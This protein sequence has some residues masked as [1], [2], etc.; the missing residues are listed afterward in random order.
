M[1]CLYYMVVLEYSPQ[2]KSCF[3]LGTKFSYNPA[4]TLLHDIDKF[5]EVTSLDAYAFRNTTALI[6]AILPAN[7]KKVGASLFVS[8]GLI[9]CTIEEGGMTSLSVSM[10]SSC[11]KQ[12]SVEIPE[13]VTSVGEGCFRRASSA[14][15]YNSLHEIVYPSTITSFGAGVHQYNGLTSFTIK[16]VNPPT[17]PDARMFTYGNLPT[18]YVPAESVDLYKGADYW[19]SW[20]NKI[21]AIPGD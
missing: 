15:A 5:P 10:F 9:K 6:D 20:K 2:G 12:T 19:S 11:A 18:I 13:G 3:P 8:S 7:V 1:E 21:Q 4:I 16:A 17:L 14:A